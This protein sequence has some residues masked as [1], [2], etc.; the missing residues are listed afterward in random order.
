M[1]PSVPLI[2][3]ARMHAC[4]HALMHLGDVEVREDAVA[5]QQLAAQRHDLAPARAV[6]R[7]DQRRLA[8]REGGRG[9]M[10]V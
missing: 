9:H 10:Q 7:L 5:A 2:S 8:P 4:M 3:D 1:P 6:P